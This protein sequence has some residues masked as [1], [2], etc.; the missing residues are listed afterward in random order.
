[1]A[2]E[3]RERPPAQQA[4]SFITYRIQPAT[5]LIFTIKWQH[6]NVQ[7]PPL[8]P[9]DV[10]AC[11]AVVRILR[12]VFSQSSLPQQPRALAHKHS[13]SRGHNST[14]LHRVLQKHMRATADLTPRHCM[15]LAAW[16]VKTTQ[17]PH[18][19]LRPPPP[20]THARIAQTLYS[21]HQL[22]M[23]SVLLLTSRHLREAKKSKDSRRQATSR[24]QKQR[25]P[26]RVAYNTPTCARKEHQAT[27]RT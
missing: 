12:P 6:P 15:L 11:V 4:T 3:S 24:K 21:T 10:A 1:M 17:I 18:D 27:A 7:H 25:A 19:L 9:P 16:T 22:N 2:P 23:R 8:K 20:R 26:Q 5:C 14:H 13:S